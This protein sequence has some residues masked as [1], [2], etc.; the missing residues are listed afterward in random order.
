MSVS[1]RMARLSRE[2][3][4]EPS[5][6]NVMQTVFEHNTMVELDG[7]D[8]FTG[9]ILFR[10][11]IARVGRSSNFAFAD[12]RSS[13]QSPCARQVK[14]ERPNTTGEAEGATAE[15]EAWQMQ[16]KSD[17]ANAL[18]IRIEQAKKGGFL[19]FSQCPFTSV[20]NADFATVRPPHL[21]GAHV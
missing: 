16:S 10:C 5:S 7:W 9:A 12:A 6:L 11:E 4:S 14:R 1:E 2:K 15:A 18:L 8:I 17:N 3:L 19:H 13:R 21:F 20:R